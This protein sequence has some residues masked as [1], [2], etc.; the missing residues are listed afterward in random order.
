LQRSDEVNRARRRPLARLGPWTLGFLLFACAAGLAR[1]ATHG[2]AAQELPA[3][4]ID[5]MRADSAA[6]AGADQTAI[7]VGGTSADL[8]VEEFAIHVPP[9]RSRPLTPL[10]VL[11]GM[12]GTGSDEADALRQQAD[13]FGWAVLAPTFGYGDWRDPAELRIEDPANATR[14]ATMLDRLPDLIGHNTRRHALVYGFSRGAQTAHRFALAF[15]RRVEAV[16]MMS[17]GTYTLPVSST[18]GTM[19]LP[20]PFGVSD[21]PDL[22]GW[23]FDADDFSS[24]PFW[25]GV[26]SQDVDPSDV[27]H[28]WDPYLGDERVERAQ[29]YARWL[30]RAGVQAQVQVF[31]GTGHGETAETRSAAVRFLARVDEADGTGNPSS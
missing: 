14:I 7:D 22:F 20:F 1:L 28:Q 10:V 6:Q 16:A 27:P 3:A 26:G 9:L 29:S 8:Q 2:A 11:H 15:P 21:F 30:R 13:E 31:P 17:S 12:G 24:I 25:I 23:S 5:P 18:D 19:A 4:P